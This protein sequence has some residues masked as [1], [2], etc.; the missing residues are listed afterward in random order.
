MSMGS[1]A[2]K[3]FD[4]KKIVIIGAG[5]SGL[6]A[7]KYLLAQKAF[8]SVVIFEQQYE[9][10]GVWNYS[11]TA[12]QTL[13]VPQVSV[14][15]PP[16]PPL[17]PKD[18]PPVFPTPMYE[19]LHTNI[20]RSLMQF[21]DL[22]LPQDSL[23]FPS[24]QDVQAYL[25][26]YAADIRHLI[27]FS[28]Q[29]QDV[30][31]RQDNGRDQWDVDVL[32]LETGEVDTTTYDAV[33][34]ASGHYSITYMPDVKNIAVF[35]AAHPGVVS[36]SKHY[37]TAEGFANKKVVAVGNAASGL[38]I[39]SQISRVCKK[40]LLLS[41]RTATPKPSL[42]FSGGEEVPVI[43]EFLV[44]ERG[45]RFQDGRVEKDIDAVIFAT[46]YLFTFPF[47]TSLKPPLVTNGR[48]VYGVYKELFDIDHP[49]L[50]F[51]GL[52][53]KVT[54]ISMSETQGAIISRTWA[55]LLPLPGPE[56]MRK[57]E[58]EEAEKRGP[59][60]HVWPKGGDIEYINAMH[61]WLMRSRTS[62]KEPP[63]WNEELVWQRQI[64]AEAK[65]KFEKEGQKAHSLAELGFE[66]RPQQD[67]DT[68]GGSAPAETLL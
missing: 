53:I 35:H 62:G 6:A 15:C 27:R 16:D 34:V 55:N 3:Q 65:L 17:R 59:S 36:H 50:A 4:V 13:H 33:V 67:P 21:S 38:D 37:R 48:R 1:Q 22:P 63:Y 57:W 19:V 46:G 47:L 14:D 7:A 45:V 51:P 10:G 52:P 41:V 60:F 49:T 11:A 5:P 20:P 23:I 40:P 31:L 68:A 8:E 12:S 64:F 2:P 29:V 18:T 24:R 66:Y 26:K 43:E 25:V 58:S 32:S 28:T 44:D 30:R 39:A 61:D 54:P 9:V 42:E 56:E